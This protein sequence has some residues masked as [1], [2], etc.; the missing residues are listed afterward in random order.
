M[1]FSLAIDYL[2]DLTTFMMMMMLLLSCPFSKFHAASVA[3]ISDSQIR[4]QYWGSVKYA[5]HGAQQFPSL[6]DIY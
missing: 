5:K 1:E 2:L 4:A 6:R 3:H